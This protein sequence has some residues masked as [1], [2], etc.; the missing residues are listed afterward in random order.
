[1]MILGCRVPG[2]P[3]SRV[4]L[5]MRHSGTR[6]LGNLGTALV[7]LVLAACR[8]AGPGSPIAPL[9][10]STPDAA[11]AQ[12]RARRESFTGARSLMRVRA[13]SGEKR[14]SFTAR[15]SVDRNRHVEVR[16]FSPVGTTVATLI[17]DG[18]QFRLDGAELQGQAAEVARI[19]SAVKPYD[20]ALLLLGIPP[21]GDIHMEATQTGLSRADV[22]DV[23]IV[24]EPP[25]FPPRN[26]KVT[27]GDD[28]L[29]IAH[30]EIV[31][32]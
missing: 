1:M 22:G 6:S 32:D 20:L 2:F 12:L 16:V 21:E 25:V 5:A 19:F 29:E 27:R 24:F 18:D 3:G 23:V 30:Q 17:A 9:T 15:L 28:A 8:T 4:S 10:A 13:I 14:Q 11:L 26:V 31:A 7:L